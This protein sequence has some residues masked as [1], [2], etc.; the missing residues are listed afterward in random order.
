[1]AA[2]FSFV[3]GGPWQR[4]LARL[5]LG[6]PSRRAVVLALVGWLPLVLLAAARGRLLGPAPAGPLLY[7]FAAHARW[8]VAV[9]VLVC[10]EAVVDARLARAVAHLADA[11]LLDEDALARAL[12]D[13]ARLRDHRLPDAVFVAL[14]Y[15][16]TWTAA[17]LHYPSRA[18]AW[19]FDPDGSFSPAGWWLALLATPLFQILLW[20]WLWRLARW[21]L[22]LRAIARLPLR[23]TASHPDRAGGLAFLGRA[24][25][26]FQS[27]VFAVS[28]VL[29]AAWGRRVV[30]GVPL[31]ALQAPI[32][33]FAIAAAVISLA[34]LLWL[35]PPLL[36][37]RRHAE[38]TFGALGAHYTQS[39]EEKWT[40]GRAEIPL[41]SA[42]LQSLA[43]LANS[44]AVVRTMRVVPLDRRDLG[45]VAVAALG[46]ILVLVVA[47]VPVSEIVK[48]LA[49][50]LVR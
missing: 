18:S 21:T 1:M 2:R 49:S 22:F 50:A 19:A 36:R 3:V 44:V 47:T 12:A 7:D 35:V 38:H 20:Q 16:V 9:P 5:G 28:S 37:T 45:A 8:L 25:L 32:I 29:A 30:E 34:P 48:A 11:R 6:R 27:L 4:L 40:T 13:A 24:H 43:D 15:G 33:V 17:A 14:A 23:L 46:P 31:R 39:F 41:G 10:A 26:S 42:D